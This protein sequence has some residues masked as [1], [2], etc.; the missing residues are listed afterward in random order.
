MLSYLGQGWE[1]DMDMQQAM[2]AS[3]QDA[4]E[5]SREAMDLIDRMVTEKHGSQA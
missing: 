4:E 2:L 1:K 5:A 3:M